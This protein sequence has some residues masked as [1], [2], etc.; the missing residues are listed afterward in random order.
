MN[1]KAILILVF[2]MSLFILSGC[3]FDSTN[4]A[5]SEDPRACYKDAAISK[6]SAFYCSLMPKQKIGFDYSRD[7]CYFK[8]AQKSNSSKDCDEI[9]HSKGDISKENCATNIAKQSKDPLDCKI[10]SGSKKT[11]CITEIA[12]VITG[13]DIEQLNERIRNM[14]QTI[15]GINDKD[16]KKEMNSD[17]REL[18]IQRNKIIN[19]ASPEVQREFM[20]EQRKKI[21]DSLKDDDV[22]QSVIDEFLDYKYKNKKATVTESVVEMNRIK[23]EKETMKKLDDNANKLI[24]DLKNN[25]I[26]YGSDKAS[27]AI[28]GASKAA[29]DWTWKKGTSRMKSQM[30]KLE[31]MK[32]T[33]DKASAKY[34]AISGQIEKFKKIYDEVSEVYGKV[35]KFNKL[36][37]DGKIDKGRA[38]VLKGAVILGKG[39]EYATNY[40][41][42]FGSTVSTVTKEVFDVTVKLAVKKA[43]RSTSLDKCF[44]DPLNCDLEGITGY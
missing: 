20:R 23:K 18:R 39:L 17:Y 30:A 12:K 5:E 29:W 34:K 19:Q 36:L 10:L 9:K 27:E 43:K 41:P 35:E 31:R 14:K 2:V 28:E 15:A 7:E 16:A 25:V 44:D 37:A 11:R 4:C 32:G 13:Q 6:G 38:K 22:K 1:E 21:L 42:V 33:Y 26:S 24:D 40:V 8:V 3:D